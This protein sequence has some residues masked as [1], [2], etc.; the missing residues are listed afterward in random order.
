M[1]ERRGEADER[2]LTEDDVRAEHAKSANPRAHWL[3]LA[4]VLLLGFVLMI[5]LI[6][7]LGATG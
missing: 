4:G 7:L 6:A 1:G 5:V 3:Y 2:H